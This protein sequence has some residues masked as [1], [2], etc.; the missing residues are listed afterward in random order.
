MEDLQK[1]PQ[2]EK[3]KVAKLENELRVIRVTGPGGFPV[4][5]ERHI[6][7][8][9]YFLQGGENDPEE[10]GDLE[11]QNSTAG[12]STVNSNP[13]LASCP[14]QDIERSELHI[15]D[16]KVIK[17]GDRDNVRP[18]KRAGSAVCGRAFD[19]GSPC[20]EEMCLYVEFGPNP[21]P[22]TRPPLNEYRNED[23]DYVRFVK[24]RSYGGS[25][26]SS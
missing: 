24:F 3:E 26:F 2:A 9:K 19:F 8:A 7:H 14:V 12:D 5:A 25:P 1:D 6:Q 18:T 15:G 20:D 23:I 11:L 13:N 10:V 22:D 17:I 16:K 21:F 4:Y